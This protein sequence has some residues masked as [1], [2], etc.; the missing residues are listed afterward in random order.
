M[1]AVQGPSEFA[2]I[3]PRALCRYYQIVGPL[4]GVSY[5]AGRLR[6]PKFEPTQRAERYVGLAA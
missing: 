2:L 3:T 6:Y 5:E 4:W 1:E